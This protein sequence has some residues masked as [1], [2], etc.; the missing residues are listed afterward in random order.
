MKNKNWL[1]HL[2]WTAVA[3]AMALSSAVPA[4]D[5]PPQV[6]KEGL[7]LQ[8]N[9]K[10]TLIYVRPG[11][12]WDQYNKL[13]LLD[14]YVEFDKGWE[15]DYNTSR[16]SMSDRVTDGDMERIKKDLAAE[17]KKVFTKELQDNGGFPV[18]DH[19]GPGVLVLRPAII[20][21]RVTA[22]DLMSPGINSTV[23]QSAGSATL[24]I[25]LW[26]S[27][28]DTIMARAMDAQADPGF[29]GR[30]QVANRVTNQMAAEQ[31]LKGW[32]TKLRKYLQAAR[33]KP[34]EPAKP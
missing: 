23:V 2:A 16:V 14:C 33:A 6:S 28:S 18:V 15:R 21:L 7:Q 29:A 25:E 20:N 4:A 8:K 26:D 31:I 34:A 12:T 27:G 10:S 5:P 1:R 32:A 11:A 24:Y 19:G 3:A 22:P 30:G 13:A 17:F 9:T